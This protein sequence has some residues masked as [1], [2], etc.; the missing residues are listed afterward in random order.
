[1]RVSKCILIAFVL[2]SL[3]AAAQTQAAPAP[4]QPAAAA[5]PAMPMAQPPAQAT[6]VQSGPAQAQPPQAAAPTTLDQVV[7]RVVEREHGL[8]EMLKTRTPIV[9]TYLQNL[10]LD[11]QLGPVPK[12]DRYFLGRID[13]SESIDRKSYLNDESM[14]KSLLG[15]FTRL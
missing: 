8:M 7:D 2:V 11:P 1:M 13:L 3:G 14:E 10:Q 12:D 15:G 4:Q 5:S 9:E 6:P